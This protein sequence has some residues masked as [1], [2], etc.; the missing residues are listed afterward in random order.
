MTGGNRGIGK[1]ISFALSEEGS[2]VAVHYNKDKEGAES[3]VQ[4]IRESGGKAEIFQAN[5]SEREI[6]APRWIDAVTGL[7]EFKINSQRLFLK[8]SS[9][10][11][12]SDLEN[13]GALMF[14]CKSTTPI[15][16][17]AFPA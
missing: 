6:P 11:S 3:V 1:F 15:R 13:P 8:S 4:E 5:V 2:S 14:N 16:I 17:C 9:S 12:N 10:I 7:V